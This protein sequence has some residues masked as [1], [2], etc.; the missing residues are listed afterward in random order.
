MY[1]IVL[2]NNCDRKF[3]IRW[4]ISSTFPFMLHR[5]STDTQFR[6]HQYSSLSSVHFIFSWMGSNQREWHQITK[7]ASCQCWHY[8]DESVQSQQHLSWHAIQKHVLRW[9]IGRRTWFV[10][11]KNRF[12]NNN[13]TLSFIHTNDLPYYFSCAFTSTDSFTYEHNVC[14]KYSQW[15]ARKLIWQ[16][17]SVNLHSFNYL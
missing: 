16:I 3:I 2:S 8:T 13:A 14:A 5:I 7:F 15:S 4:M 9:P 17:V 11:G 1:S 6:T 10:P 12:S